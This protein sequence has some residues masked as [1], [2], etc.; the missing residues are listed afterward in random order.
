MNSRRVEGFMNDAERLFNDRLDVPS[1]ISLSHGLQAQFR[2][3]LQTS[4]ICM[5]P[6]F[7]HTLPTGD[8]RGSYLAVDVGGSNCRVALVDLGVNSMRIVKLLGFSI[9][10]KVRSLKGVEFFDWMA[11]RIEEIT[12]CPEVQQVLGH[13]PYITGVAWSFPVK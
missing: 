5:L 4:D 10:S 12:V 11:A 3:R 7:N 9:T 6:S 2:Q 1:L 8:E 13:G